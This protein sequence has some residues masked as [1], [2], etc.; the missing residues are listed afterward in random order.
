MVQRCLHMQHCNHQPSIKKNTTQK[1]PKPKTH[2][3]NPTNKKQT[4]NPNLTKIPKQTNP[5]QKRAVSNYLQ[6]IGKKRFLTLLRA[7]LSW[8]VLA[9]SLTTTWNKAFSWLIK[10]WAFWWHFLSATYLTFQAV[11]KSGF[12]SS[13]VHVISISSKMMEQQTLRLATICTQLD[14]SALPYSLSFLS[15]SA[16]GCCTS[17]K[18]CSYSRNERAPIN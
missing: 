6:H 15:L 13:R 18:Y 4:K 12:S 8:Q 1:N 14:L 3:K 5:K 9:A 10:A 16:M 7:L 11:V 2:K 17:V